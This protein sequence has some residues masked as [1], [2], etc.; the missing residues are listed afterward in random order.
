MLEIEIAWGGKNHPY[1]LNDGEHSVGRSGDC[2]IKLAVARVSKSHAM[3]RVDGDRL[4]VRDL[5]STNG[6][7]VDGARIGLDEVE[8]RAG[9]LVSFAGTLLRRANSMPISQSFVEPAQVTTRLHYNYQDGYS[10]TARDRIVDMSSG[11]FE[12]LASG[13]DSETVGTAACKF[14]SRWVDADRV[15][16]LED[17][18]EATPVE[19]RARWTR[20]G[21]VNAPL[22]L[23]STIVGRVIRGRESVLVANPLEDPNFIDQHSILSL[24]LR[25]AMAAPLFDNQRVR[26]I[27]YVDT[28]SPEVQ[29]GQDDLEVLT[30]T[31]NAVAIKL[32][33]ISFER[34][35]RTA[36]N[37][38][39]AMLPDSIDPPEGYELEA[40]QVMCRAVG[41][42]LYQCL[43]RV[44]GRYMFAL[45]DVSGKGMP[46]A[47]AMGAGTVLVGMLAEIEGDLKV[48]AGH[49]HRQLYRSLTPEQFIT[50]F[51]A[52]L[53]AETGN[54]YYVNAGHEPPLIVRADGTID[55][56]ESTGLPVGMIEDV[57]L[58]AGEGR[59]EKGDLL[60]VFSDGVPEATTDGEK[61]LGMEAVRK[62]ISDGR[63]KPLDEV[64]GRIVSA[65]DEF[66]AGEPNSDDVTLMLLR[67]RAG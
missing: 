59:L 37:I 33:N 25:S 18:G 36:A 4:F 19:A 43:P 34:D 14:V 29:Y 65:V 24:N 54:I 21:D 5:G 9:A 62:I 64:R 50:M 12:L 13:S 53:D 7:E 49:L 35:M 41:G 51:L 11:L 2:D 1:K 15:V 27:L 57:M 47:L 58:E 17:R 61:F 44:N 38:Q 63:D 20:E 8:A 40:Y 32:R 28:A 67:R 52:E 66:L 42:D 56:L 16:L 22:Q 55:A 23:S 6:T 26:G 60:A 3:V 31:A 30:A 46:A 10:P 45:G 39:R 48:L